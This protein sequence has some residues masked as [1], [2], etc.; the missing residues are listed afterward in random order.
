MS[1]GSTHDNILCDAKTKFKNK[2]QTV[3]APSSELL[4][5]HSKLFSLVFS[6]FSH[7]NQLSPRNVTESKYKQRKWLDSLFRCRKK[8]WQTRVNFLEPRSSKG[9]QIKKWSEIQ[10]NISLLDNR[11]IF[12]QPFVPFHLFQLVVACKVFCFVFLLLFC[13]KKKTN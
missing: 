11:L 7:N 3:F 8:F 12:I 5:F 6:C 10:N 4:T 2:F 9:N 1:L 13:K